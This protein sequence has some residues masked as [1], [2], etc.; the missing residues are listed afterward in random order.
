MWVGHEL[1]RDV[2]VSLH[3]QQLPKLAA[4]GSARQR[5]ASQSGSADSALSPPHVREGQSEGVAP[6]QREGRLEGEVER[7]K[8][9]LA[10]VCVCV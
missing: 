9:E 7:L 4:R 8:G 2:A 3:S 6:S 5:T 10:K 1:H